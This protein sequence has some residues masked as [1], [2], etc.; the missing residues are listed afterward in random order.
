MD[1]CLTATQPALPRE[2]W[3]DV[4]LHKD[5]LDP[6]VLFRCACF[7]SFFFFF[8]VLTRMRTILE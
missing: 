2:I 4:F 6:Y 5:L 8:L 3:N 1:A 7:F